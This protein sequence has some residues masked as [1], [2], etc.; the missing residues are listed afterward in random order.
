M[1]VKY[2]RVTTNE[3][4]NWFWTKCNQ[5]FFFIETLIPFQYTHTHTH[6]Y[7]YYLLYLI[8]SFAVDG[9]SNIHLIISLWK[10]DIPPNL[11]SCKI[12]LICLFFFLIF[13]ATLGGPFN[14]KSHIFIQFNSGKRFLNCFSVPQMAPSFL[15][16]NIAFFPFYLFFISSIHY[17][18]CW[19]I[20]IYPLSFNSAFF[21]FWLLCV[22]FWE[23][24]S[25]SFSGSLIQPSLW[26]FNI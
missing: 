4:S 9:N 11:W 20:S 19:V 26:P 18:W 16:L 3:V 10:I 1:S 12:S 22:D 6:N 14:P 13:H 24:C 17:M 25:V 5:N 8:L 7:L 23:H 2:W 15:F 21:S